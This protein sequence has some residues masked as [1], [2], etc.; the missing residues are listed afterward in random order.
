MPETSVSTQGN[1]KTINPNLIPFK[2]G[3]S[4]NPAGRPKGCRNKL[5][6]DFIK[7]LADD[8]SENGID[9]IAIARRTDPVQYLKVIAA[10]VPK[11]V[12]HTVEDYGDLSDSDLERELR[13]AAGALKALREAEGGGRQKALPAPLPQ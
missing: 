1:Q 13:A 5:G 11:E 10:V 4:G 8:F 7:A 6:E 12:I 2:P 9:A 3:Q